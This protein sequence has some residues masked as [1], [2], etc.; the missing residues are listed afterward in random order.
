MH[1]VQMEKVRKR[2]RLYERKAHSINH[3]FDGGCHGVTISSGVLQQTTG[4]S[5]CWP[6]LQLHRDPHGPTAQPHSIKETSG[7]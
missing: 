4:L 1:R 7:D 6:S 3:G 5:C 2:W